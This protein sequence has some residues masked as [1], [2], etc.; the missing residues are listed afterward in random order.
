MYNHERNGVL[1]CRQVI[2]TLE[3][4]CNSNFLALLTLYPSYALF[5][6]GKNKMK[7]K[8]KPVL[9][10]TEG[11]YLIKLQK[12]YIHMIM[13]HLP[14][15][16]IYESIIP[17]IHLKKLL[18]FEQYD[19]NLRGRKQHEKQYENFKGLR[20]KR[21]CSESTKRSSAADPAI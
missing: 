13:I 18:G 20:T 16:K 19:L 21:F 11:K 14:S 10:L 4:H 15:C 8:K 9:Q 17:R 2:A 7:I 5:Q 3:R 12:V 6:E 1:L